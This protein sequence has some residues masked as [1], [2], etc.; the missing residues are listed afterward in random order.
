MLTDMTGEEDYRQN[1]PFI[2]P[3]DWHDLTL[4]TG[5]SG[6]DLEFPD[7]LNQASHEYSIII[8][9]AVEPER[10]RNVDLVKNRLQFPNTLIIIT[11]GSSIQQ[12]QAHRLKDT[13]MS[14]GGTESNI[15]S[16]EEVSK[17][18][19]LRQQFCLFLIE[20][21]KPLLADLDAHTFVMLQHV[22]TRVQGLIWTTNG[23]SNAQ[24]QLHTH[25][26]NGLSRVAR[27]EFNN[28]VFVTLALEN[29][30]IGSDSPVRKILQVFED[31][32]AQSEEDFESE[33]RERDGMLEIGRVLEASNL[34]QEI[35]VKN[36]SHQYKTAEFGQGPPLALQIASPGLLNSLQFVED[37]T[38]AKPLASGEV[39]IQV[40]AS[41]VNF[42]DCLT[43]L[44][45][46]DT[47]VLG[48]ECSGVVTRVAADCHKFRPGDR[49]AALFT[50]TY[51]TFA[52]G[53]A[54]C[55]TKIPDSL[56]Y[57]E[58]SALPVVFFTAW[59]GLC[60][61]A[62]LQRGESVLIH[63]G[64]GGTGQ[65]AIQV[66]KNIGAEIYV[67]VGSDEKRKLLME[68]YDV[69]E[70]HI[71]YSRNTSFAQGVMRMTG[72][73]GVDVVLNS[74]S[75]EGLVASWECIAPVSHGR[76]VPVG[77]VTNLLLSLVASSR[78]GNVTSTLMVIC[79][80]GNSTRMR[81][82]RQSIFSL[83]WNSDH[84]SWAGLSKRSWL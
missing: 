67:T 82:F 57:A 72:N 8:T 80:C 22:I 73:K 36:S 41:G 71:F 5:F 63:A 11:E 46:L 20:V 15:V 77:V 3:K 24:E 37:F 43:A 19:D 81:P 6:V 12:T 62:R 84:H 78:S 34:N 16:L 56:T 28:L 79:Q 4:R 64:A 40:E 2:S 52:R 26:I 27:T 47:K 54:L 65:A 14:N 21:E 42:R 76:E 13:L 23:G 38:P 29:A 59:Y 31:T 55:T 51:R 18:V 61:I 70:D 7:Y 69:P 9:T 58:A 66:A 50:N 74:L 83:L 53:P 17:I 1:G 30:T 39:E 32:Q 45:Q 35:N 48:G 75:G 44:G 33:Y 49:V 60:D 68:T 10:D 25:L